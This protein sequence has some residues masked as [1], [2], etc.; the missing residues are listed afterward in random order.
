[1]RCPLCK[2]NLEKT[3]PIYAQNISGSLTY[4]EFVCTRCKVLDIENISAFKL[5]TYEH[6]DYE[7]Q[8]P[9]SIINTSISILNYKL[10]IDFIKEKILIYKMSK[11]F[12]YFAN[13]DYVNHSKILEMNIPDNFNIFDIEKDRLYEKIVLWVA[14]S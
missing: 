9:T 11:R 13:K 1:M 10:Y 14:L 12:D 6:K 2:N 8:N 3:R 4:N 5:E 7:L